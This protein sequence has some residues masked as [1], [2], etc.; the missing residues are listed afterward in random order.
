MKDY[1]GAITS[2]KDDIITGYHHVCRDLQK[3]GRPVGQPG[4]IDS[5]I[6]KAADDK[7][8]NV[9][10]IDPKPRLV[11][12]DYKKPAWDAPGWQ[13]QLKK[14]RSAEIVV[15][16]WGNADDVNLQRTSWTKELSH[17]ESFRGNH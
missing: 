5:L 6:K 9:L 3:I 2:A 13:N 17:Q 8:K 11:I 7:D 16:G 4:K 14:I 10:E 12:I 1:E 15:K